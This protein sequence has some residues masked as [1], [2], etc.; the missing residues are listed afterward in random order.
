MATF[1]N[2]SSLGD[3]LEKDDARL[4]QTEG[5]SSSGVDERLRGP[6]ATAAGG[7]VGGGSF[8]RLASAASAAVAGGDG[9]GDAAVAAAA[10]EA[11]K[12][13]VKEQ[14]EAGLDVLKPPEAS[15]VDIRIAMIG[16][17][18]SGKSTLIGV[19]SSSGLDDGRGAA[20]S[21]VLRHRH[22]QEN[23][24]TSAVTMEIMGYA[25]D[26]QQVVPT[27]R[28]HLQRWAEVVNH[29][30]RSVTLIDLCGHEKY[31]KTTVFGLTGLMPDFCLLVV[32]AN[33][34]VQRMTKEHISIACAL[35]IPIAVVVTKI[36]ICP[37]TVLKQT[38]QALAKYL[39]QNQKMPYPIKELSQVDAA[40]ESI[41]SDR[42][43]PVFAVSNVTGMGLPLLRAFVARL[44]RN[45]ARN[46][47]PTMQISESDLPVVHFPIDGVYEVRGVGIVVGGTMLRGSVTVNQTLLIGPDRAGDFIQVTV[48]SIECK[49][50]GVK[51]VNEGQSATFAVRSMN[52]RVALRRST[53]RKGMVAIDGHDDPRAT[54][55]FEADVV[56]LHHSTTVA[57][58]YQPVIHCGVVRQA[59]AILS[60]SG[61]ESGMEALRTGQTATV[62]FRF[63]YYS[64]YMVLGSTFLF[65]EGR[66]KGIGKIRRVIN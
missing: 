9:D 51:E 26:G 35:Q 62:R 64:E 57:P 5:D 47:D 48:R 30:D 40:A 34:G 10:T 24:R 36:D 66:A 41:A 18:D 15:S 58:G 12:A 63:M 16:N 49:R 3:H 33:M 38:R 28:S 32:G 2:L 14:Q 4:H 22:E 46:D 53:F 17:V 52:R 50:Q 59:A 23:G 60:M 29:S 65:R 61:T 20:R 27:A 19:L 39:R 21:L 56:I 11:T 31:L 7:D 6:G 1:S 42:I 8:D 54:R 13:A 55:E 44:R 45:K 37:P 43:T 25:K